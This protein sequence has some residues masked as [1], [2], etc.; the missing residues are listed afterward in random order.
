MGLSCPGGFCEKESGGGG[1][2]LVFAPDEAYPP[3]GLSSRVAQCEKWVKLGCGDLPYY[4]T[5]KGAV[6]GC[7]HDCPAEQPNLTEHHSFLAEV[8]RANPSLWSELSLLRTH[9]GVTFA[10]CIKPGIDCK[11]HPSLRSP[12]VVAGDEECYTV[13][14][15]LFEK[16]IAWGCPEF[17]PERELQTAGMDVSRL[18]LRDIDPSARYVQSVRA[19]G[20]RNIRGIRMCPRM[21]MQER[22]MVEALVGQSV[23]S[24]RGDLE[25]EYHALRGS[26]SWSQQPEGM[27][28]VTEAAL[29]HNG[30]LFQMPSHPQKLSAGL[31]RHWPD[32]RGVFSNRHRDF[33]VWVNEEDHLRIMAQ[34]RGRGKQVGEDAVPRE[35]RDLRSIVVRY[36]RAVG[37]IQKALGSRAEFARDKRLGWLSVDPMKVGSGFSCSVS[38]LL[39][40]LSGVREFKETSVALGL[41]VKLL[42]R[43]TGC[44]EVSNRV[45]I[46][47]STVATFNT[48]VEG[49]AQL[50]DWERRLA[51]GDESVAEEIKTHASAPRPESL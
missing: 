8:L 23:L 31:G 22:R 2:D 41:K 3:F 37:E 4:C 12:G 50:V 48:V 39:P 45:Q 33:F 14:R 32:G 47:V 42:D 25:G 15:P 17:R 20:W 26:R 49:C 10:D 24:L 30:G 44:W 34:P 18:S 5:E 9:K 13:F 19:Y 38:V 35:R 46:G 1:Q 40:L 28:E 7:D 11:G 51:A 36:L 27:T 21:S 6:F 16:V 43:E 29:Q